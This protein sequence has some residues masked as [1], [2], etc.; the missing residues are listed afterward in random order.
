MVLVRVNLVMKISND[1]ANW[2]VSDFDVAMNRSVAHLDIIFHTA[3]CVPGVAKNADEKRSMFVRF[4]VGRI[5]MEE[6]L[7]STPLT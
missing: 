7:F 4:V 2:Q 5:A 6:V 3:I 1:T